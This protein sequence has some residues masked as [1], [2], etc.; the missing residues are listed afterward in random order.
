MGDELDVAALHRLF[1]VARPKTLTGDAL[2]SALTALYESTLPHLERILKRPDGARVLQLVF[3]RGDASL[4]AR[5][6]ADLTPHL[7]IIATTQY[8]YH[9]M[10]SILKHSPVTTISF[11]VQQF[12]GKFDLLLAHGVGM[13]VADGLWNHAPRAQHS[14]ILCDFYGSKWKNQGESFS[15]ICGKGATDRRAAIDALTKNLTKAADKGAGRYGLTHKLLSVL[16]EADP[17]VLPQFVIYLKDFAFGSLGS[18]LMIAGITKAKPAEVFVSLKLLEDAG[19]PHPQGGDAEEDADEA[20]EARVPRTTAG[21]LAAD[22]WGWRVLSCAI[23]FL[24]DVAVVTSEVLPNLVRDWPLLRDSPHA[25]KLFLRLV[26][27]VPSVFRG[28][29]FQRREVNAALAAAAAPLLTPHAVADA[30]TLGL[31][32]DGSRLVVALMAAARGTDAF[33]QLTNAVFVDSNLVDPALHKLVR[34]VVAG[35]LVETEF[36][37][38]AIERVGLGVVL[39]SPGAWIIAEMVKT[40]RE[41]GESVRALIEAE[42]IAGKAIEAILNPRTDIEFDR[43]KPFRRGKR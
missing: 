22:A 39:R 41:F 5:V 1:E 8:S 24:E 11:L 12:I 30:A 29:D 10:D 26:S 28:L 35:G 4:R 27:A 6:L 13:R 43:R 38:A 23:S 40:E 16:A 25:L 15:A 36:V 9:I 42:G 14:L 34:A 20:G 21:R 3:R 7:W 31:F 17:A 32:P 18:E 33:Q 19:E 37:H 2:Q